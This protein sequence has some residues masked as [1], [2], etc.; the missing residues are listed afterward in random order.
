MSTLGRAGFGWLFGVLYQRWGSGSIFGCCWGWPL[1][2]A[3]LLWLGKRVS[4]KTYENRPSENQQM[5]GFLFRR[6]GGYLPW[7]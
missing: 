5:A 3:G 4:A 6:F 7:R 2:S 1:I